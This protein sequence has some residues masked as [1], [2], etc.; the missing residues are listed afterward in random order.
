[1]KKESTSSST[2]IRFGTD[3]W[4]AII[5]DSFTVANVRII[6][7]A[8]ADHLKDQPTPPAGIAIGYDTRFLSA[9][10][11]RTAAEVIAANDIPVV[12]S[13][14]FIPTPVLS[15]AVRH[16]RLSGGLMI[17]ASHNPY[18]YNGIKFKAETGGSASSALTQAIEAKL[19]QQPPRQADERTNRL[20]RTQDLF[21]PYKKHILE[22]ID[23]DRLGHTQEKVLYNPMHGAGSGF[24]NQLFSELGIPHISMN[25]KPD[26]TFGGQLP[27]PIPGNLADQSRRLCGGTSTLGI[28]TDGDA[29][30]FGVLDARGTFVQLH[31]CMPLLFRYLVESRGWSGNVVRSTSMAD[32][33]D[34]MA[35]QMG[36]SVTEVP[37]G[38][39]NIC[40]T[41]LQQ[42]ILI[43]GEESGGFGYKNHIP[44]RD[45][46]L[47]ALLLLEMLAEY[48]T[49]VGELV[50]ELRKKYGPFHYGRIDRHHD[51]TV[52]RANLLQLI[53]DPPERW[54][55]FKVDRVSTVDGI[56]FYFTDGSWMLMRVSQT[57]PLARVYVGSDEYTKVESLLGQGVARLIH[58]LQ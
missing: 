34:R 32:T 51:A 29:D 7:Q 26:P 57:E 20:I 40:E 2:L 3:G 6:A 14:R 18:I 54:Q 42:D 21:M 45:G 8:V 49:S 43:G 41:M 30:R 27:E 23:T 28:A 55:S 50:R 11:A 58:P 33:I 9:N 4:R 39:K 35:S 17:T 13:D 22:Y 15:F 25:T 10:F 36:R 38:F 48:Q 31:D 5:A 12:L 56:K 37:V 53:N 44:E 1:M 46:L 19:Q 47:S 24:L 52:L 16:Y